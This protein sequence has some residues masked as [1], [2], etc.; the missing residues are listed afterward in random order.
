MTENTPTA[1][2]RRYPGHEAAAFLRLPLSL[3]AGVWGWEGCGNGRDD[4]PGYT[5]SY[6]VMSLRGGRAPVASQHLRKSVLSTGSWSAQQGRGHLS[7]P[8]LDN[9]RSRISV[10]TS[11]PAPGLKTEMDA[12]GPAFETHVFDSDFG[13]GAICSSSR[14]VSA[15]TQNRSFGSS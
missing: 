4:H 15:L 11:Q 14:P 13:I 1:E 6:G 7:R 9:G 8:R 2:Q 3:Y 12:V 5:I 10:V